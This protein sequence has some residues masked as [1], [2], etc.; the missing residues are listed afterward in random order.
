MIGSDEG[1]GLLKLDAAEY[2]E[3][4]CQDAAV[5]SGLSIG[6]GYCVAGN[7]YNAGRV[8]PEKLNKYALKTF[9]INLNESFYAS[10]TFN[11]LSLCINQVLIT[12]FLHSVFHSAP[13]YFSASPMCNYK[14][15]SS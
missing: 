6:Y 15:F 8:R 12:I 5:I 13:D 7:G 3:G 2:I 11:F 14:A 4:V 10:E 1:Y 9:Q